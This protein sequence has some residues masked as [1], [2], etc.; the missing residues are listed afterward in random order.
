MAIEVVF[1]GVV[2][3]PSEFEIHLG[4][5]VYPWGEF[6]KKRLK[7]VSMNCMKGQMLLCQFRFASF[8]IKS[9]LI[10]CHYIWASGV[11]LIC[12][13]HRRHPHRLEKMY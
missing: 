12:T 13:L 10:V 7:L 6:D 1:E 4:T 8:Q 3:R 2:L 5:I 9:K 11:G